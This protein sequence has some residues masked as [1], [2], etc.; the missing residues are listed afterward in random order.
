MSFWRDPWL[1]SGALVESC[2]ITAHPELKVRECRLEDGWDV[3]LIRA[4]V[5]DNKMEEILGY[6]GAH[7]EGTDLLIWEPNLNGDSMSKSAWDCI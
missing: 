2:T 4:L 6:L 1:K 5:G 3:D 7:K